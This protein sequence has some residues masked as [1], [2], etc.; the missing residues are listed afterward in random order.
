MNR[1]T[2]I[3]IISIVLAFIAGFII[4]SFMDN[5]EERLGLNETTQNLVEISEEND[6]GEVTDEC[7]DEWNEYNEYVG[8]KIEE[9]SN[10]LLEDD[11]HYL[12][13]DA[14]GYIE[15]YYLGE[16]N[17][18]YLYKKTNISTDYLTEEDLDDLKVGIEVVGAEALNKMLEDF[19]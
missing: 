13:K 5:G 12:L 1:K 7:I 16:D 15:V 8:Q 11:T 18:E 9:A 6:I 3:W 17:K 14:N 10:N 19:E 2:L 4:Y